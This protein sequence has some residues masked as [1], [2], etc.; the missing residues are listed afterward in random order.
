LAARTEERD[1]ALRPLK[2]MMND[3]G[4]TS[5]CWRDRQAH[6]EPDCMS[7]AC[8]LTRKALGIDSLRDDEMDAVRAVLRAP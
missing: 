8:E 5:L 4:H 3:Y 7:E 1:A 6:G 2:M